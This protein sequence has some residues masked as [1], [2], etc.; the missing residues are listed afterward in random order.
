[1]SQTNRVPSIE[2]ST[3]EAL[4][5]GTETVSLPAKAFAT[6]Q[7]RVLD[8][9]GNTVSVPFYRDLK[10]SNFVGSNRVTVRVRDITQGL[11]AMA[12]SQMRWLE[13]LGDDPIVLTQDFYELFLAC[14]QVRRAS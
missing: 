10:K 12:S 8:T 3:I 6:E 11:Q 14:Q 1:M 4:Y 2:L 7:L 5:D 13:D 9:E